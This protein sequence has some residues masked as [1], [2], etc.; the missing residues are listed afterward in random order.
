MNFKQFF[1]EL[2]QADA[3]L[4]YAKIK[5]SAI[6]KD[7]KEAE[8][9]YLKLIDSVVNEATNHL[10]DV[11]DTADKF[12]IP[13]KK[14]RDYMAKFGAVIKKKS[15][16]A[17]WVDNS[18]EWNPESKNAAKD[19]DVMDAQ[20]N[21][22]V[23]TFNEP[24][25]YSAGQE[26]AAYFYTSDKIV[27][28][29]GNK[30]YLHQEFYIASKLKG[31]LNLLP[32]LDT[33]KVDV[34]A[35]EA[36]VKELFGIVMEKLVTEN[37]SPAILSAAKKASNYVE[38]VLIDIKANPDMSIDNVNARLSMEGIKSDG[39]LSKPE[40]EALNDLFTIT[41]EILK[42]TG[43]LVGADYFPTAPGTR[44]NIGK[45]AKKKTGG[46]GVSS[47]DLGRGQSDLA[48]FDVKTKKSKTSD[49]ETT[50]TTLTI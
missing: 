32:I 29:L 38:M 21:I 5:A 25:E 26:S 34:T 14:F 48:T 3:F 24:W 28:F 20:G 2:Y 35:E 10:H 44:P 15:G 23:P 17:R 46:V 45:F 12:V 7:I 31:K 1:N 33:V 40:Q 18:K 6:L 4:S 22:K 9:I 11:M 13:S 16:N 43:Y 47:F 37:L 36:P 39:K 49:S 8:E 27:K 41:K 42:E 19:P 50:F 30:A